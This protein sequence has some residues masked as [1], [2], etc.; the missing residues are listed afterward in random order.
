MELN[1]FSEIRIFACIR[2]YC[3]K[4]ANQRFVSL[5]WQKLKV[6]GSKQP[7]SQSLL[8]QL[9]RIRPSIEEI[10]HSR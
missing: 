9:I 6:D 5:R 10:D 2:D 4:F 8:S 3:E 7:L 1:H